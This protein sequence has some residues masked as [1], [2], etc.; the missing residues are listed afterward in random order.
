MYPNHSGVVAQLAECYTS[1]LDLAA[2][3]SGVRSVAFCCISTG[4][5]GFPKDCAAQVAITTV[6]RWLQDN[7]DAMDA[8]VF[9]VYEDRDRTLY[10]KYLAEEVSV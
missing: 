8:V 9:N 7:P 6:R 3:V 4:V 10:E 1:C 5:F 2:R